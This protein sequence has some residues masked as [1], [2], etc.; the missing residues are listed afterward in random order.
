MNRIETMLSEAI[1]AHCLHEAVPG[2]KI[3]ETFLFQSYYHE[4][5]SISTELM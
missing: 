4:V 2:D 3:A 1:S 5:D